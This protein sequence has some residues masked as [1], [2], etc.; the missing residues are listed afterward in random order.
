MM[1][2]EGQAVRS[3]KAGIRL[4]KIARISS[5]L[6]LICVALLVFS[7]WGIT[8]TGVIYEIT[9]G[10]IDRRIAN[11]IHRAVNLPLA[12]FFLLHVFINIGLSVKSKKSYIKQIVNWGLFAL[13]ALVLGA[14]IYMEYFR[15]GG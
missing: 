12:V 15:L 7:G 13:G 10:L 9:G 3:R 8:Q 4:K 2:I 11:E 6:L 14:V 1:A 5:W